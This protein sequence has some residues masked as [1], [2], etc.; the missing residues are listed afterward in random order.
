[1][2]TLFHQYLNND[3]KFDRGL[4]LRFL[5]STLKNFEEMLT[6]APIITFVGHMRYLIEARSFNLI[7]SNVKSEVLDVMD[8]MYIVYSILCIVWL[9]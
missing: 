2:L 5:S 8:T 4:Y 9:L 7:S 6:D 1:M 3:V